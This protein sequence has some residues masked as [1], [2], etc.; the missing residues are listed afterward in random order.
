MVIEIAFFVFFVFVLFVLPWLI[1][2][3]TGI[4]DYGR[5]FGVM[6]AVVVVLIA[7]IYVIVEVRARSRSDAHWGEQ[8]ARWE[9][10]FE[11]QRIREAEEQRQ[12]DAECNAA[13]EA[14]EDPSVG[15]FEREQRRQASDRVC[16]P[17]LFEEQEEEPVGSNVSDNEC[18][19]VMCNNGIKPVRV[20]RDMAA[21]DQGLQMTEGSESETRKKIYECYKTKRMCGSGSGSGSGSSSGRQPL[22]LQS[23]SSSRS[24]PLALQ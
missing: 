1:P 24:R 14:A 9:A 21:V 12:Q 23:G 16:H 18:E 10:R 3:C 19:E 8:Q 17:E 13:L 6:L 5:W 22:A 11:A 7:L 15:D 4:W 2:Y 20:K